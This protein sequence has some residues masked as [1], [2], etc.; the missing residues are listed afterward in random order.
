MIRNLDIN[1]IIINKNKLFLETFFELDYSIIIESK[2]LVKIIYCVFYFNFEEEDSLFYG[3]LYK[4]NA[5]NYLIFNKND[6]SRLYFS[7]YCPYIYGIFYI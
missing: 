3:Y 6:N 4:L 7:I 2:Y 5:R 1:N